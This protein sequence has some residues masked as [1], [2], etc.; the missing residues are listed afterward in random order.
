MAEINL[1][2]SQAHSSAIKTQGK[3]WLLR[4]ITIVFFAALIGYVL[5][6]IWGWTTNSSIAK[7]KTEIA[8]YQADIKD[9]QQRQELLTRQGQLKNVNQLLASH[10]YWSPVLPELARVTLTSAKYTSITADAKGELELTVITPSYAEAEKYL[11]VFDLPEYNKQFSN[12]KVMALTKAQVGDLLQTTM[13]LR[14]TLNP[15]FLKK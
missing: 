13:R 3:L 4:I 12:V 2:D 10:K 1:L 11:Q 6:F 8:Q 14:L 9:N 15:S 7:E 5:L